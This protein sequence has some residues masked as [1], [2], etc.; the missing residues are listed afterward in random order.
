MKSI[1]AKK[2]LCFPDGATQNTKYFK[3]YTINRPS[4]LTKNVLMYS[5]L[6]YN[7]R[8]STCLNV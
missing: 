4:Y 5:H 3:Q 1:W 8:Y 2:S 6:N 7:S